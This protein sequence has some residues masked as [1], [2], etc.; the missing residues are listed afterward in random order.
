MNSQDKSKK[1]GALRR[2]AKSNSL[3]ILIILLAMCLL[4]TIMVDNG[5]TVEDVIVEH[6]VYGQLVG[7]LMLSSRYDVAEFI[8]K[9]SESGSKPLSDLTGG[10]HLHTLRCPDEAAFQRVQEELDREGLL[11]KN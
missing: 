8:R 2:P 6:S 9:V 1:S 5:C 4:L 7:Q 11:V 3:G 10:I